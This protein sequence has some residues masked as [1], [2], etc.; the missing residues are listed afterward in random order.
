MKFGRQSQTKRPDRTIVRAHFR[1]SAIVRDMGGLRFGLLGF[2]A[3]LV[4]LGGCGG[5]TS[6]LDPD[7]TVSV[8]PN[9]PG[10]G[11]KGGA[12]NAGP[13][14]NAG[15]GAVT[16][17]PGGTGVPLP[18]GTAGTSSSV[19][20]MTGVGASSSGG[21]AAT[22]AGGA[23]PGTGASGNAGGA[24]SAGGSVSVGGIDSTAFTNCIDYCTT[25]AP[26][27]PCT[28]GLSVADC[29]SSCTLELG[30]LDLACQRVASNLLQCLTTVYKNSKDCGDVQA[31]SA[32][33]CSTLFASYES[34][35]SQFP[36][37]PPT[38]TPTPIPAGCSGSGSSGGGTCST[39]V[40][41]ENGASY[42][43][44]CAQTS[45]SRASC[46]CYR[47]FADGSSA[48][49]SF[50]LNQSEY[51]ACQDTMALCG[52]PQLGLK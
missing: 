15:T 43:A 30:R 23:W 44:V 32:S 36:E 29:A 10:D 28:S 47:T 49:S 31:L 40:K 4:V 14:P 8:Q 18:G 17:T 9:R 1:R 27:Q 39:Y 35:S 46:T 50:E 13:K 22:G 7:D 26:P 45:P 33:K 2:G 25:S 20:G 48:G 19:G 24:L 52:F 3:S 21:A 41:C 51:F 37:P 42:S 38:P 5:R 34:C 6:T 16:G 11:S 12:S